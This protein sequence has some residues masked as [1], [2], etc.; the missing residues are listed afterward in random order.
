MQRPAPKPYNETADA[1]KLIDDAVKAAATDGIRVLVNWGA[2]DDDGSV[3]FAKAR[4]GRDLLT[5]WSDEYKV[6]N[7]DVGHL[8][9]NLDTAKAFGVTL[10]AGDLPALAVLDATGRILARTSATALKSDA[11]TTAFDPAKIATFLRTHQAPAPEANPLFETAVRQ[12]K[13]DGKNRVRVVLGPLVKVVPCW[14][15]G[16]WMALPNVA[17]VL[18][19]EFVIVKLDF[20]R[21][22]GAQAIEKRYTDKDQGLPW[23]VFVDGDGR[24]LISSTGTGADPTNIGHPDKPEEVAYFKIMLKRVKAHLSDDDIAFLIKTLVDANQASGSGG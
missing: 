11:D 20:D 12:A 8:D 16:A 9:K 2:N 1:Q 23:F 5:F 4:T 3:R 14:K 17:P 6:A 24:A 21:A 15:L 18:A 7:I 10:S 13:R 19:R 22:I